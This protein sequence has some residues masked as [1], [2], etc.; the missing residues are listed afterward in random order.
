MKRLA[1]LSVVV[2]APAFAQIQQQA[3]TLTFPT[4]TADQDWQ[5]ATSLM[6]AYAVGGYA[7]AKS[8]G[9]SPEAYGHKSAEIFAWSD[10][11]A[12]P[13]GYARSMANN[14]RALKGCT[15]EML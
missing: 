14:F 5:R 1:L 9:M 12:S 4:Y 15:T 11:A 7:I 13:I 8:Q 10:G 3:K 2:A 6:Y